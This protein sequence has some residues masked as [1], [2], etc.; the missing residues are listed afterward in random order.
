MALS[1]NPAKCFFGL[2][3]GV[4]L[5]HVVSA[6]GIA[7]DSSKVEVIVDLPHPQTL[8][9]VRGVSGYFN[10]YRPKIEMFVEI[11]MP[12]TKMLKN[13]AD[14]TCNSKQEKVFATLKEKLINA[15]CLM[16]PNWKSPFHVYF[17]A[18]AIAMGAALCQPCQEGRD[19]PIAFVSKQFTLL[20]RTTPPSTQ[21]TCDGF[22]GKNI[23]ITFSL[24]KSSLCQSHGFE[25]LSLTR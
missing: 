19:R 23:V 1:L 6:K 9:K 22:L 4:L 15:L 16:P 20:R 21:G 7:T 13:G 2:E 10:W 12:I 5:G 18:S 14:M 24:I 11:I 17:D 3:Y 8:T 25:V